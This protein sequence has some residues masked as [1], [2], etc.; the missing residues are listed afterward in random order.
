MP[1]RTAIQIADRVVATISNMPKGTKIDILILTTLLCFYEEDHERFQEII[2]GDLKFQ[3]KSGNEAGLNEYILDHFENC[4][5]LIKMQINPMEII[6]TLTP[7]DYGP[8]LNTFGLATYVFS[9]RLYLV[10]V[11]IK[12]FSAPSFIFI[13][14]INSQ[15][16]E[17]API[18][19]L[20]KELITN[21]KKEPQRIGLL[22]FKILNIHYQVDSIKAS[23]YR[24]YVEL[25]SALDLIEEETQND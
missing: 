3:N 25:A 10:E 21:S 24:D 6:C 13:S 7:S 5:S 15:Y 2:A 16:D 4:E 17:I 9:L 12:F 14:S 19:D 22:W 18:N 23:K 11:F 8:R 20:F 1:P